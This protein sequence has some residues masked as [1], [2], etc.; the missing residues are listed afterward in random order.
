MS[1][2]KKAKKVCKIVFYKKVYFYEF[3]KEKNFLLQYYENVYFYES[4][5][6]FYI[7]KCMMIYNH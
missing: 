4:N 3:F 7:K 2:K 6:N 1:F 5:A